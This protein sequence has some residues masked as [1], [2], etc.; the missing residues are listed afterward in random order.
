LRPVAILSEN[1]AREMWGTPNAALGKRIRENPKGVWKEVIGVVGNER[2]N[3]VDQKAP[4]IV[5]WPYLKGGFYDSGVDVRRTLV[6]AIRSKRTGSES[7]LK[8]VQQAVWSVNANLPLANVRT[9]A[10]IYNRSM[11]RSAFT[12]VILAIAAG[13]A[14][15][16]G[17]VGIY[18]V[19]SYSIAQ[20]TREI[21]IRIALGSPHDKVRA[22]FVRNGLI[23]SGIG[24]IC[25]IAVAVPLARLM[26]ALL[27]EV[28][29][30]DPYTYLAVAAVLLAA[31]MA[32][33]YLPARRATR[34]DPMEA[35][36][37]E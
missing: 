5:Y 23:L 21:G 27:F 31:A 18:G 25:G 14:L 35:L 12:L 26:S 37:A 32:A 7:L 19:I 28:S 9:V 34:I 10:E 29:P 13:M 20:R 16:L 30:L 4:T 8:E 2:D 3:G 1:F 6:Y 24:V 11:A 36:R 15:L 17:V 33:S 22:L